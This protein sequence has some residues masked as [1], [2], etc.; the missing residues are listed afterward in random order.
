VRVD[1]A[2]ERNVPSSSYAFA[3]LFLEEEIGRRRRRRRRR[4]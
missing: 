4:E 2:R 3:V 1:S